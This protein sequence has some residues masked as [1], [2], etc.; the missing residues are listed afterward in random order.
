MFHRVV[1]LLGVVVFLGALVVGCEKKSADV[2][3]DLSKKLPPPPVASGAEGKKAMQQGT[4]PVNKA[5]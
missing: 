2:P 3:T 5:D 1:S 4:A